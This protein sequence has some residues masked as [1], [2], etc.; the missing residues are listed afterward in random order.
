MED[1]T[2]G[3][4]FHVGEKEHPIYA[5]SFDKDSRTLLAGDGKGQLVEYDLDLQ[6]GR[7]QAIKNHGNLGIGHIYSSS[8]DVTGLVFFGGDKSKVRVYDLSS[9][10]ML[11]GDIDTAI[12]HILSLQVCLVDKSR[13][14]LAAVRQKANYSSTKS[15][16]YD[17][18]ELLGK[19]S[20]PSGLLSDYKLLRT[21][22]KSNN[23]STQ[24]KSTETL[25]E[26]LAR[27]K[28]Q[29]TQKILDHDAL[30]AR[31]K[32][33][34]KRNT[35]LEKE[36]A[37][38]EDTFSTLTKAND[39]LNQRVSKVESKLKK[40]KNR[41][42]ETLDQ[43]SSI[44]AKL[45]KLKKTSNAR[46]NRLGLK[47]RIINLKRKEQNSPNPRKAKQIQNQPDPADLIRDL[48][49]KLYVKTSE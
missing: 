36:K 21:Q 40:Y 49:H 10:Q 5:L 47:L 18:S 6:K 42:L 34:L 17:L 32:E 45:H 22:P 9:R 19:D 4:R 16:L 2:T 26:K 38:R 20:L 35:R 30:L 13:V 15:D 39:G 11:P 14:Y 28:T 25:E 46:I 1:L 44:Q 24:N 23:L 41:L 27:L 12:N 3:S 8:S 33:L 37:S 7:G 43:K 29:L 31:N 48:Q